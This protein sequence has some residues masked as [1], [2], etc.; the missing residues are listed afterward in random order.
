M[1]V[2][3]RAVE[4]IVAHVDPQAMH[5]AGQEARNRGGVMKSM[6]AGVV[7]T[8]TES[9]KTVAVLS[10]RICSGLNQR[11]APLPAELVRV[12]LADSQR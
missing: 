7:A 4:R 5:A 8:R 3:V 6:V 2:A 12:V 9:R 1:P 10:A 11:P